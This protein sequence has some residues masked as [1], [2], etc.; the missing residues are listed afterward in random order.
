GSF[1]MM[2]RD[3]DGSYWTP[4]RLELY[5]VDRATG[6]RS[7]SIVLDDHWERLT[8]VALHDGRLWAHYDANAD[9]LVTSIDPATGVETP[10]YRVGYG[11][12]PM[13]VHDGTLYLGQTD[14]SSVIE[15]RDLESGAITDHLWAEGFQASLRGLAIVQPPGGAA[16]ELWG[17][18]QANNVLTILVDRV[19]HA[20]AVLPGFGSN[21][22]G[23]LM[24]AGQQLI[25]VVDG[26]LYFYDV[27]R[28]S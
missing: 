6:E 7:P 5:Q 11:F 1:W 3:D 16:P 8:G 25:V 15:L 10:R 18:S 21:Q 28:P 17:S 23:G 19:P 22:V 20:E 13:A 14:V 27:V 26:Q 4:D 24:F 2:D 12:G 9:G